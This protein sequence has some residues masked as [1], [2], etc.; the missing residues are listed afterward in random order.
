M[1][2]HLARTEYPVG[3]HAEKL[4]YFLKLIYPISL[5]MLGF[6]ALGLW[7]AY[8][9]WVKYAKRLH[10]AYEENGTTVERMAALSDDQ[11]ALLGSIEARFNEERENWA[12]KVEDRD[13]EL[14]IRAEK[15]TEADAHSIRIQAEADAFSSNLQTQL[16]AKIAELEAFNQNFNAVVGEKDEE[17]KQLGSEVSKTTALRKELAEMIHIAADL[18]S[19]LKGKTNLRDRLD[20]LEGILAGREA[21]VRELREKLEMGD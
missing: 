4:L 18:R 8:L 9:F 20:E 3:E 10:T 2:T 15:L 21:Q 6:F 7:L 11:N 13:K 12:T 19:E 17:I 5:L 16:D 1:I 14:E